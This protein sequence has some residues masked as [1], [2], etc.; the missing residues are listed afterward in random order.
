MNIIQTATASVALLSALGGTLWVGLAEFN[1]IRAEA[2][3]KYVPLSEWQDFQWSQI[4][5]DIRALEKEIAEAEFRGMDEYADKLQ[6]E[7]DDLIEFLCRKY[8]DDRDC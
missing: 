4:K 3:A 1:N 8:P 5:R 7:L 6:D 2:D